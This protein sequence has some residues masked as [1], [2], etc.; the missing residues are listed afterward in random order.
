MR[1]VARQKCL[2]KLALRDFTKKL[3]LSNIL[4]SVKLAKPTES[5]S[6][7][8][9]CE[10]LSVIILRACIYIPLHTMVDCCSKVCVSS[11]G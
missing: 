6:A 9:I 10:T 8:L 5:K 1:R 3:L 4:L 2:L 11:L 7:I